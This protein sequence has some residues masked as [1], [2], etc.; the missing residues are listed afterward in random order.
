MSEK[1]KELPP[2]SLRRTIFNLLPLVILTWY[3][4]MNRPDKHPEYQLDVCGQTMHKIGVAL[5]KDRLLS[6]DKLYNSD[7]SK[8]FPDGALPG[9]PLGGQDAYIQGYQVSPDRS[10]Y[11]LVC[12]GNHHTDSGVP[13]DYPRIAFS[14]QEATVKDQSDSPNQENSQP[15]AAPSPQES[16]GSEQTPLPQESPE[17]QASPTPGETPNP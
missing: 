12:K 2:P 9:C 4:C 17:P 11:V 7:L 10:S 14:V 5:E 15:D 3:L 16:P 8:V 13:S 1:A 6:E